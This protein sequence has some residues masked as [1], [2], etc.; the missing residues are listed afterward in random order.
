VKRRFIV[1][2]RKT[3]RNTVWQVYDL[4]RGSLP[5]ITAE[6]GVVRQDHPNEEE[7]QA[8]CDRL[9]ALVS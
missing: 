3:G 1:K 9:E 7:A 8:E 5:A 6:L 2:S 4:R